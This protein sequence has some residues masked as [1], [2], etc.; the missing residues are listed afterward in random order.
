MTT[1]NLARTDQALPTEA[2]LEKVRRFL[3]GVVDGARKDDKRAW[4][5]L[6]KRILDLGVGEFAVIEMRIPRNP[7]FHR[8]FFALL[9]VGFEAWEP[10]RKR[11]T[12]KGMAVTKNF[13]QFREDVTILAGFYEQSFDLD[14]RMKLRAKSISFANMEEPEFEQLYSAVAD[15]LLAKV[16]HTY[17]GR[18]E[19]DEVV[20][21]IVGFL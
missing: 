4:R 3:F 16:L 19:L 6:W 10:P 9:N 17:L 15:V 2:D 13:D 14:G 7:R 20:E 18:A 5:K 12:Y 21:R 1:I 11:K 8:K